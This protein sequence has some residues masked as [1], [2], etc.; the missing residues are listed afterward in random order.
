MTAPGLA[1]A[2]V[3][4]L[5]PATPDEVYNEW[6]SPEALLDWMCPRPARCLKV[7]IEPRLG[8][9]L[10]IDIEDAGEQF[11]VHGTYTELD[12][13]TRL[14]FSWSCS[15]WPDPTLTSHVLVTL[16]PHGDNQTLMTISHSALTPDQ[17]D[18]HLQGWRLIAAQ[19]EA[20]LRHDC[21]GPLAP[22]I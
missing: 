17:V 2:I 22:S 20:A 21:R 16:I 5:L 7:E 10:R 11:Y 15:T 14:G 4:R 6:V 19:L 9:R 12:R 1:I 18:Q 3:E 13:P 8:G